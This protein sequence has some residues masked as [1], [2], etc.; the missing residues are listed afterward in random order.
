MII[1][2][3][4]PFVEWLETNGA[5]SYAASTACG[6]N[7]RRYHGLLVAALDPPV[8]RHVLLSKLEETIEGGGQLYELSTNN[9]RGAVHPRGLDNIQLCARDPFPRVVWKLD[10]IQIEK[11][12]AMARRERTVAIRYR[13]IS[14]GNIKLTLRPLVAFRADHWLCRTDEVFS[15][16][17]RDRG[18]FISIAPRPSMPEL[19][20]SY[21]KRPIAPAEKGHGWYYHF[22]Y[23]WERKR[24]FESEEDLYHPFSL[25][26][27]LAEGEELWISASVDRRVFGNLNLQIE[28]ERRRRETLKIFGDPAADALA[29]AADSF[30]IE[31]ANATTIFAGYPWFV[32]WGRDTMISLPGLCCTTGRYR[33]ARDILQIFSE[34]ARGGMLPNRFP[35]AAGDLEYNTVDATLWLFEAAKVLYEAGGENREFILNELYPKLKLAIESYEKGGDFGIYTDSLGFVHSG[36]EGTAL[37]W[38]DARVD[39]APV[40]PR[41]GRAVEIQALWYHANRMIRIFAGARREKKVSDQAAARMQQ[42]EENFEKTFW[43]DG[44]N[45]YSDVVAGDGASDVS[46]RPNQIFIMS[47]APELAGDRRAA[48]ALEAVRRSLVT[49]AGL[50]TLDP[51]SKNYKKSYGGPPAERDAAYHQGTVWPWLLG[52]FARAWGAFFDKKSAHAFLTD[53]L[54]KTTDPFPR[55]IYEIAGGDAPHEPDGCFAQAWNVAELLRTTVEL[56]NLKRRRDAEH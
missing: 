55:P 47:L 6:R 11:T 31:R 16:E 43:L 51:N 14:G 27:S 17:F 21:S 8:G 18:D 1:A 44:Q 12:V 3:E 20:F 10:H 23:I 39:G 7:D 56:R 33:E 35:D 45:Y 53:I 15:G 9:Y 49:P 28:E 32:D 30:L 22:E 41:R 38:M 37:T 24:G 54:L 52:P 46:L 29:V 34:H 4:T 48:N 40:T 5:G 2:A 25:A 36:A 13:L 50:R 26:F 42:L 19:Y